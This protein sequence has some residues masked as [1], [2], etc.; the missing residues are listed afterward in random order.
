MGYPLMGRWA[1]SA[2]PGKETDEPVK[3]S[4]QRFSNGDAGSS[5]GGGPDRGDRDIPRYAPWNER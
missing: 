5:P 3:R 4:E 1:K 2:D